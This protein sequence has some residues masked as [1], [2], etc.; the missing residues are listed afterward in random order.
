MRYAGEVVADHALCRGRRQ[1]IVERVSGWRG[2]RCG[3]GAIGADGRR[4]ASCSV[5]AAGRVS[6]AG[7]RRLVMRGVDHEAPVA[8]LDRI[9]LTA[10]RNRL[11]MLLDE[12]EPGG[13]P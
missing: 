10:I 4:C 11:D 3:A 8:M 2:R 5:A 6:G 9:K 7:G 1:W 13:L 12:D